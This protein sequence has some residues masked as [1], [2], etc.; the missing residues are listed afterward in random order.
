MKKVTMALTGILCL[1]LVG[2]SATAL[3]QKVTLQTDRW[4]VAAIGEE[5]QTSLQIKNSA[6]KATKK[7]YLKKLEALDEKVQSMR[8]AASTRSMADQ[9]AD[10]EK[11]NKLWDNML[12]EIYGT[13]KKTAAAGSI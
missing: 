9:R 2:S 10:A 12:N 6:Q 11:S 13:L 1:G 3:A 7:E 5:T 4:R 8:N